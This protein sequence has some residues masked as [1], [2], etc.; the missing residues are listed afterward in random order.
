MTPGGGRAALYA[1]R[2]VAVEVTGAQPTAIAGS[3]VEAIREQWLV[4]DRWWSSEPLRRHYFEAVLASGRC[5]VVFCDLG[6]KRWYE[7]R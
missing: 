7:Q 2:A 1:P 3:R 6:S 5:V 4:E